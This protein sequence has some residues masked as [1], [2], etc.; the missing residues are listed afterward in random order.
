MHTTTSR[1]TTGRWGWLVG[2]AVLLAGCGGGGGGGGGGGSDNQ[3]ARLEFDRPS[4]LMTAPGEERQLSVR[5]VNASGEQIDAAVT[6]N[7]SRPEQVSVDASGKVRAVTPIGSAMIFAEAGGVRS[8][9]AFI[10]TVELKPGTLLLRDIDVV[11]VAPPPTGGSFPGPGTQYDIWI[12]G[13]QAPAVGTIVIAAETAKVSGRVVEAEVEP[14]RVRVRLERLAV[15]DLL[16]RYD[17][18][19]VIDLAPYDIV[20]DS[21]PSGARQQ[22]QGARN[23]PLAAGAGAVPEW[24]IPANGEES[25]CSAS[26][27]AKLKAKPLQVKIAGSPTLEAISSKF[28][29]SLPPGRLRVALVGDFYIET[30]VGL[31]AEAGIEGEAKCELKGHIP[32]PFL[33]VPLNVILKVP[34]GIGVAVKGTVEIVSIDIGFSG[35]NGAN[36]EMGIDCAPPQPC[37]GL[38]KAE[39]IN[40]FTPNMK[41]SSLEAQGL[42]VE[43]EA[44]AYFLTGIDV[45][46]GIGDASWQFNLLDVKVGPKQ[47]GDFGTIKRQIDDVP[48]ASKYDLAF[49]LEVGPG[50]AIKDGIKELIGS[51][52]G[53]L[54]F[55]LDIPF[56]I[57]ESPRGT[58][59]PDKTT[60]IPNR[61][62]V[63]LAIDLTEFSTKYWLLGYNVESVEIYKK[64]EGEMNFS[65]YR[66]LPAVEPQAHFETTWDPAPA[67]A[68]RNDFVVFAVSKL[69]V[70]RLE[71]A[72]MKSVQVGCIPAGGNARAQ[73]AA[74]GGVCK[75]EW[76]GSASGVLTDLVD[77]TTV[78]PLQWEPDPLLQLGP[79][80][81]AL[82]AKGSVKVTFLVYKNLGC[83]VTPEVFDS[84]DPAT[85][86]MSVDRNFNPAKYTFNVGISS[87]ITIRCPGADPLTFPTRVLNIQGAG[88]LT[89]QGTVM[90]GGTNS[91]QGQYSYRFQLKVD[92]PAPPPPGTAALGRGTP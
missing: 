63:K 17:V 83:T 54:S 31:T 12:A 25:P 34:V 13:A 84:F 41:L 36:L 40:D 22:T 56:K 4:A 65:H 8:A 42:K 86:L 55:G 71:V 57:S 62:T 46:L 16:A 37:V 1:G 50:T 30:S 75:E 69:P 89:E 60:A 80:I 39:R 44:G 26:V 48:Y 51:E 19:W 29:D 67:D 53:E 38:D 59:A 23:R 2:A 78:T 58:W 76:I 11:Q 33:P 82:R 88:D 66:T 24:K 14:N 32:L 3:V 6:W 9:P 72:S 21:P 43:L 52:G 35:K 68:G 10:A 64:H 87:E 61:D 77:F 90:A 18:N 45:V 5:T 49:V 92:E 73:G 70:V 85:T 79:N 20:I 74:G 91:P 28:D 15:P 27:E 47:K 81:S 7:S